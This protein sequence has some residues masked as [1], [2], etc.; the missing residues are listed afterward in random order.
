M[1]FYNELKRRQVLRVGLAYIA[2]AWLIVQ[3]ANLLVHTLTGPVWVMPMLMMASVI[4]FPLAVLFAWRYEITPE[5]LRDERDVDRSFASTEKA[6]SPVDK[7][8]IVMLVSA[9]ALLILDK[10]V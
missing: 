2:A 9:A 4:G 3:V 6:S 10:F 7:V 5:G 1:S 8:I